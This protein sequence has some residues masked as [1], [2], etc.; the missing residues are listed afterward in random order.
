MYTLNLLLVLFVFVCI[1][2]LFDVKG[3]AYYLIACVIHMDNMLHGMGFWVA[4]N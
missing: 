3:V 1:L 2:L 4:R